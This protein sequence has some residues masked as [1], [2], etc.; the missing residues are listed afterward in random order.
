MSSIL[1]GQK[2]RKKAKGNED[3]RNKDDKILKKT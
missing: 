2:R 1:K 3:S